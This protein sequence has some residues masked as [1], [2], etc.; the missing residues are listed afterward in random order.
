MPIRVGASKSG[1]LFWKT[2]DGR[3]LLKEINGILDFYEPVC[4]VSLPIPP[5]LSGGFGFSM[6]DIHPTR[7]QDTELGGFNNQLRDDGTV[8]DATTKHVVGTAR[9]TIN[10]AMAFA[11]FKKP[12][13]KV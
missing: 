11:L 3:Y 4:E 1:A 2:G 9:Y 6:N 7:P 5:R 13:H 10:Y 12:R 8:Y